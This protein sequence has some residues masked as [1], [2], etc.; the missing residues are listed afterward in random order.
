[1]PCCS[2]P[3]AI[4]STFFRIAATLY[5]AKAIQR[6][7]TIGK[8]RGNFKIT[9]IK[10]GRGNH[11]MLYKASRGLK[12]SDLFDAGA[13]SKINMPTSC[14][15]CD[16]PCVHAVA[17]GVYAW[18]AVHEVTQCDHAVHDLMSTT[19]CPPAETP[20]PVNETAVLAECK[21]KGDRQ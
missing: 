18:T 15:K 21:A 20:N 14:I 8:V 4:E 13:S 16:A 6:P 5:A 19:C 7:S 1:L 17:T 11:K 3:P 9:W 2:T 10:M 12:F